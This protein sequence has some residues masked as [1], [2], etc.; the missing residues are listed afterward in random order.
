V[1]VLKWTEIARKT[2]LKR[3][4]M[5]IDSPKIQQ[6]LLDAREVDNSVT[7]KWLRV[8][9]DAGA[10]RAAPELEKEEEATVGTDAGGASA[11]NVVAWRDWNAA[12]IVEWLVTIDP[13]F[14][15]YRDGIVEQDCPGIGAHL[16]D[17]Y[18]EVLELMG[19]SDSNDQARIAQAAKE[20]P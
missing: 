13:L 6:L 16:E 5:I 10:F 4:E 19:V 17:L 1:A 9:G 7:K 15:K 20:L 8:E 14:E 2:Q 18:D 3:V 11:S 12:Q